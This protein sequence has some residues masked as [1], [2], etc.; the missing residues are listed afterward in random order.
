R[1]GTFLSREVRDLPLVSM[2]PLSLART[3]P[4]A[5]DPA[6]SFLFATR[7]YPDKG[8]ATLFPINGQRPRANNYLLDSTENNDIS[9]TGVAQPFN[10]ADAVDEVSVQTGN[11]GV[12]LGRAGGGVFNVVTKSGTNSFHGTT[13]WRYQSERFNSVSNVDKLGQTPQS[14]FSHNVY[15]FTLGGPVHRDRTFFFAGFQQDTSRSTQNISLTVPTEAA[16]VRLRSLFPSNPRLDLY[17]KFLGSL[18][19][20]AAP[21]PLQLGDDPITGVDRGLV[22]FASAP[23]S[24]PA[25]SGGPQW[26]VRMDHNRSEEHR[27]AFRYIYDT[28]TN[29]PQRVYFPGFIADQAA[30]NHNFLFTDHYRFSPTWTN[31]FRFSYARQDADEPQ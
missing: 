22:L 4:G 8:E 6:G 31:E 14:V 27:L 21:F 15:G 30:L 28:R 10:M 24:L 12:E 20:M 11:F 26:L 7:L 1:G 23:F 9:F 25:S 3:L 5:V 13:L 19:G 16:V 17:L 18:R 2:N 29:S